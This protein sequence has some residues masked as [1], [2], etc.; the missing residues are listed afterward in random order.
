MLFQAADPASKTASK[1]LNQPVVD[2]PL[3]NISGQA[4]HKEEMDTVMACH[5]S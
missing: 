3:K 4:E 5:F 2:W 1:C